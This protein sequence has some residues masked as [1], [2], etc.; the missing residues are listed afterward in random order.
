VFRNVFTV[1]GTAISPRRNRDKPIPSL[2]FHL[3]DERMEPEFL[4]V[5]ILRLCEREILLKMKFIFTEPMESLDRFIEAG[6]ESWSEPVLPYFFAH[7]AKGWVWGSSVH[8]MNEGAAGVGKKSH[9]GD[10]RESR[11]SRKAREGWGTRLSGVSN[12]GVPNTGERQ[13]METTPPQSSPCAPPTT[14]SRA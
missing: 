8:S 14:A 11:P 12:N 13:T 3:C 2:P 1:W 4:E 10:D 6:N 5:R 7:F 9:A